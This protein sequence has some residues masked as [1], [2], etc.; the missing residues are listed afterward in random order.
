MST[1]EKFI[2]PIPL[3]KG[4]VSDIN[5]KK[6]L[7]LY[8]LLCKEPKHKKCLLC[9]KSKKTDTNIIYVGQNNIVLEYKYQIYKFVIPYNDSINYD[10]CEYANQFLKYTQ[11]TKCSE[12][13]IIQMPLYEITLLDSMKYEP[14]Y[15]DSCNIEKCIKDVGLFLMDIHNKRIIHNDIKIEN[16]MFYNRKWIIIDYG[17]SC[18]DDEIPLSVMQKYGTRTYRPRYNFFSNGE[19]QWSFKRN[20]IHWKYIK[21]WYS[22]SVTMLM[23][24]G[25]DR[26][27]NDIKKQLLA[28]L[29]SV[30]AIPPNY[31]VS[32]KALK[33]LKRLIKNDM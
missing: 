12:G 7:K 13:F 30:N 28:I 4:V 16:I 22:Y 10:E 21:D 18:K 31:L 23:C 32:V 2:F 15:W 8:D 24:F 14:P 9:V 29:D 20:E 33:E 25:T 19:L 27:R 26:I 6:F 11:F 17:L 3:L 1:L 5:Q